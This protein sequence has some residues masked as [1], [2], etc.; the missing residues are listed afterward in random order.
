MRLK[1][2][3]GIV[4]GAASIAFSSL[5]FLV[6]PVF[7]PGIVLAGFFGAVAG[8]IALVSGARRIALVTFTFAVTPTFGFFLLEYD[9]PRF[10]TGY[11]AFVALV[12]ALVVAVFAFVNYSRGRTGSR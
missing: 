6:M 4:T 3:I 11:L 12:I 8:I 1:P 7:T 9:F 10:H 2:S 5:C